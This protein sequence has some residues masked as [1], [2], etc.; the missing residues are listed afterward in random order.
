[1][2]A[3]L[4]RLGALVPALMLALSGCDN[5]GAQHAPGPEA[6]ASGQLVYGEVTFSPCA[7]TSASGQSVEAHCGHLQVA[8]NP[9]APDARNLELALAL[10]PATG[11]AEADPVFMLAGGPGQSALESYP[12]L[13]AAFAEVLRNRHVLLLDARGTG[14]SNP[15]HCDLD[16][17]D[18]LLSGSSPQTLEAIRSLTIAC[19][20]T[21]SERA[22]LR[23]YTTTD[24]VRDLERVRAVLGVAQLNLVGVSYG[25]RVAQ[26][27]AGTYPDKT[28][29]L[30]LDSVV[31]N[32]LVLG[33]E[34]AGNLERV[35]DRQFERCRQDPACAAALGDPRQHLAQVREDLHS[36]VPTP[37]RFRDPVTGEWREEV[38][39]FD[40]LA[41]LLRLYA[42]Q[43][44]MAASLPLLLHEAAAGQYESLLAQSRMLARE[45]GESLA[46][47][48]SLSVTCSEDAA[49][50]RED[51]DDEGTVLGP[52]FVAQTRAMCAEWPRGKRPEH[53]RVPLDGELPVLAISGE[54][55]PVTPPRYGDAV[56]E[57]LPNGRHLV[58]PGQGHNVLAVGCMPRL[59]AQFLENASTSDLDASCLEQLIAPPPFAG[60]YGW[61]P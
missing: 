61:E 3:V 49:E 28:R 27:Y 39:Q 29:A 7:L 41:M 34:H 48:M 40:H 15:L 60:R 5:T 11:V 30:I 57:A 45:L 31:P 21:L 52:G 36:R 44:A 12:D 13:Q 59:A 46:M 4:F 55:D 24:H 43:P 35:L 26:Q 19:R 33:Q 10:V 56:V 18:M 9:D 37:V 16:D 2:E 50:L 51:P 47:G 32:Q 54:F 6:N 14:A 20:D 42:Y 58:L 8:E 1:M 17:T 38:P 23:F 25:T 22:D 53:F